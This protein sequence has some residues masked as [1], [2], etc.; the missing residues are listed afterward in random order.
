[1]SQ[2]ISGEPIQQRLEQLQESFREAF[3]GRASGVCL[4]IVAND[5]ELSLIDALVA[6]EESPAAVFHDLFISI[7]A[8]AA[9]ADDFPKNC[10]NY[11]YLKIQEN[12]EDLSEAGLPDTNWAGPPQVTSFQEFL[13]YLLD[14]SNHLPWLNGRTV[15]HLEPDSFTDE[16][17]YGKQ[18][19]AVLSEGLP[20]DFILMLA[21]VA[22]GKLDQS[23]G[24]RADLE[25][26][27]LVANLNTGEIVREMIDGGDQADPTVQFQQHYLDVSEQGAKGNFEKMRVAGRKALAIAE[28]EIGWEHMVVTVLA[29][30]GSLLLSREAHRREAL[31]FFQRARREA[32]LA[33]ATGNDSAAPILLQTL[34]FEAV[35]L[36]QLK[37]YPAAATT[38]REAADKCVDED[39]LFNKFEALRMAAHCLHKAGDKRAAWDT[40]LEA[41]EIAEQLPLEII[42]NST[43]GFL[44]EEL[45]DLGVALNSGRL[46][47]EV[48]RRIEAIQGAAAGAK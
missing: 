14:F 10:A 19:R 39:H 2:L 48:Q 40:G 45:E 16:K 6:T 35:G 15:L 17:R 34:N 25:V 20:D 42:R 1:M 47:V 21:D 38:Y 7:R 4:W 44:G 13:R 37:E 27:R 22:G 32:A 18:L 23:I 11:L 9:G 30:Q 12:Q 8:E 43:I 41:L 3:T 36:Y 33:A 26:I 46:L 31:E 24:H 29:A 5:D 28:Q